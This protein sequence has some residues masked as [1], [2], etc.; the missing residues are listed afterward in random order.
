MTSLHGLAN[1]S[2][3]AQLAFDR[4]ERSPAGRQDSMAQDLLVARA[5]TVP[6]H[7]KTARTDAAQQAFS[8]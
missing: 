1:L 6:L 4:S 2:R 8:L 7:A 5:H 3:S